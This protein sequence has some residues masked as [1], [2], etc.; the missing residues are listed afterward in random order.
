MCVS[1]AITGGLWA[2]IP[3]GARRGYF[4]VKPFGSTMKNASKKAFEARIFVSKLG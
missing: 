2:Y 1:V 4:L 3:P